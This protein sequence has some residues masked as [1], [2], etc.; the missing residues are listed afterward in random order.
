MAVCAS[1][2]VAELGSDRSRGE[3]RA[4]GLGPRRTCRMRAP[5]RRFWRVAS[6]GTAQ[7]QV[8]SK[9]GAQICRC[10]SFDT[11]RLGLPCYCFPNNGER[12][13][14]GKRQHLGSSNT[15]TVRIAAP[16]EM[17]SLGS[18]ARY[19]RT[20]NRPPFRLPQLQARSAER[21]SPDRGSR[22]A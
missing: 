13:W 22:P 2:Y 3:L 7:R 16:H 8:L 18:G 4:G 21:Y 6:V 15:R 17:D 20:D 9:V 11:S 10:V 19:S 1:R 5:D 12:A 14:T